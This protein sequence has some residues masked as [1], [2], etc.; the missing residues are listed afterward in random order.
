MGPKLL[1]RGDP[2]ERIQPSITKDIERVIRRLA[3]EGGM[4]ILLVEQYN[5]FARSLEDRPFV[6]SRGEVNKAGKGADMDVDG[7]RRSLTVRP[8]RRLRGSPRDHSGFLTDCAANHR[9]NF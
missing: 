2:T 8:A 7:G 1:V 9:A 6:L 5:G 3:A 4:A